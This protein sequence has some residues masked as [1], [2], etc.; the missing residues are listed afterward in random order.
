MFASLTPSQRILAIQRITALWALNEC[1]LGGI[2]HALNSPFTGLLVGSIAMTCVA[3]ICA[4]SG[5]K[6]STVMTSLAIVLIIKALVSPQSTP[7]AYL[8][9]TFQGVTGALIY[10]YI[11]NLLFSSIFFLTLGLIESAVQRIIVL[12]LLYGNTLWDAINIWGAMIT[13]RWGVIIPVSSS[14]LIIYSYL[15][16]YTFSGLL[17]GWL[18]YR[19]IRA[20]DQLWGDQQYMLILGEEDRKTFF[21]SSGRTR[22][23]WKRYVLFFVLVVVIIVAYSGMGDQTSN[24]GRGLLS[25]IRASAILTVWFVFLAPW[26]MR[27]VQKL[28]RHKQQ[29]LA[30]DVERT[31]DMFPHLLYILDKARKETAH[32]RWWR[33]WRPF[34]IH[35]LLY[36]LQYQSTHDSDPVRS[37]A[38]R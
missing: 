3:M 30:E 2:M 26:V 24:I 6:W 20:V 13:Q 12:T 18:V 11:P 4:L 14:R 28:L 38:E 19:T 17:V 34:L 31:M 15:G 37:G 7:T 36:I 35:T 10:R 32:L 16:I 23:K 9:V 25:I 22:R 1:G 29:Q 33:R 27:W 8:A 21:K 5:N